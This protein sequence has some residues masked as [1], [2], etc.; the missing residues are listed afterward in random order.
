MNIESS[1][2]TSVV[3][4]EAELR[5]VSSGGINPKLPEGVVDLADRMEVLSRSS[6][7][8]VNLV[9]R[10][11]NVRDYI[12]K[13]YPDGDL[14]N[15]NIGLKSGNKR[16]KKWEYEDRGTH[17]FVEDPEG[18]Y[19]PHPKDRIILGQ[20]ITSDDTVLRGRHW[21]EGHQYYEDQEGVKTPL[22]TFITNGLRGNETVVDFTLLVRPEGY[23]IRK[24]S[25][26]TPIA[27]DHTVPV[28]PEVPL[29]A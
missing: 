12:Q 24:D 14:V 3:S 5:P 11:R 21:L 9:N 23:W 13:E 15:P 26:A 19:T 4:S 16:E 18:T 22:G 17:I 29:I 6:G 7:F 2:V 10:I 28:F 1:E 20:S 27:E 8:Y 25:I